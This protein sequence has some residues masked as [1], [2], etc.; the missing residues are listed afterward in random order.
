MSD[1]IDLDELIEDLGPPIL[2]ETPEQKLYRELTDDGKYKKI[3]NVRFWL[4]HE[5]YIAFDMEK[6]GYVVYKNFKDGKMKVSR[7]E[8]AR[9]YL[10]YYFNMMYLPRFENERPEM[11]H[12]LVKMEPFLDMVVAHPVIKEIIENPRKVS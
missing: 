11:Q 9:K 7:A 10:E 2:N 6:Q 8:L 5:L 12:K 1:D 4:K 3:E